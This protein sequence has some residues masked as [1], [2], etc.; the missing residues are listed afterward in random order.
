MNLHMENDRKIE[1]PEALPEQR[2]QEQQTELK[3]NAQASPEALEKNMSKIDSAAG[4][5][6]ENAEHS[7]MTE[8][9]W[10]EQQ[11]K[12]IDEVKNGEGGL[13]K[14]QEKGNYGEMKVDQDLRKK[15]YERISKD[16]VISLDS[17][18]R[19]GIDGVYYS[20]NGKPKYM[21]VDAKYGA[22]QLSKTHDGKQMSDM[23]INNRL[24]QSVGKEHADDIRL[25]R[26]WNP[27]NVVSCVS[28][29]G[30]DGN[31]TYNELDVNGNIKKDVSKKIRDK[32]KLEESYFLMYFQE[33]EKRIHKFKTALD[34]L[35]AGKETQRAQ[36][37]R[38]IAT[39]YRN[40]VSAM[41]SSGA[42]ID[43]ISNAFQVYLDYLKHAKIY[44][45][46]ETVDVLS[47]AILL[48][49]DYFSVKSVL[50]P[51]ISDPLTF[52]LESWLKNGAL[53]I[54]TQK[55]KFPSQYFH[56][57]EFLNKKENMD[58]SEIVSYAEEQ[59]YGSCNGIYW[60]NTH[61]SSE[62][63]YAGYWCWLAAAII[64]ISG[65]H[66]DRDRSYKYLPVDLI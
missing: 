44:D 27:D 12:V 17:K 8:E 51:E 32:H 56:L 13:E 63:I 21:I 25:E 49:I 66:L 52:A 1:S 36:I 48:N 19:Q 42:K 47:L 14:P 10:I 62:N 5:E 58:V 43:E 41:Y 26:V 50:N 53:E 57:W 15:G 40:Y 11:N 3:T 18:T 54:Q 16:I 9:Q 23:W 65:K 2:I 31:V 28:H 59:W 39:I 34:K 22:G 7:E 30:S 38:Y 4:T 20:K 64:K 35:L 46:E 61:K 60:H 45:Y 55:L 37:S 29:I 6:S 33:E 24:D